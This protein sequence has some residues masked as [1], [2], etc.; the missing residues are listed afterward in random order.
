[1]N[2]DLKYWK[3]RIVQLRMLVEA[4]SISEEDKEDYK[5]TLKKAR[6]QAAIC[7]VDLFIWRNVK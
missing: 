1:M 6:T 4:E 2:R 3:A 7:E 5:K